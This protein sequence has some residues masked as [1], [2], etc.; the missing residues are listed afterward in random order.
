MIHFIMFRRNVSYLKK[1]KS[2]KTFSES[3]LY[4]LFDCCY[5]L[6]SQCFAA[7]IYMGFYRNATHFRVKAFSISDNDNI[8]TWKIN[9]EN[10][11]VLAFTLAGQVRTQLRISGKFLEM[12][13][14]FYH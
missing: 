9:C 7:F 8:V 14:F 10:T 12:R 4:F 13:I 11:F 6:L 2:T 3:Y 5:V 1:H